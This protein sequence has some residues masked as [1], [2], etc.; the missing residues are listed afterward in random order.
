M[1][2]LRPLITPS[3][4]YGCVTSD[5]RVFSGRTHHSYGRLC[6][7]RAYR[8][9]MSVPDDR[10]IPAMEG[11]LSSV[12]DPDSIAGAAGHMLARHSFQLDPNRARKP[13]GHLLGCHWKLHVL[14]AGCSVVGDEQPLVGN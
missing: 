6:L 10:P 9:S 2:M 1:E 12:I 3:L 11:V 7:G 13:T 14:L 8:L 5:K 4:P